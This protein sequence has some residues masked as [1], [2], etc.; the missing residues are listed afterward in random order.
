MFKLRPYQQQAVEAVYGHLR[1]RDDNPCVVLPTGTG[2]SVVLAQIAADS[3]QRWSGRVLILAHVKEL[4][5]Q[6]ADKI[7]R[8]CPELDVG[9]YSAG[10]NRRDTYHSVIAAGIQSVYKRAEELGAFDIVTVDEAHLIAP[11]GEG[12][13]RSFLADA[14]IINPNLRIIGLTATPF[15]MKGGLICKP[16]N[17]LNHICYEAGLKEMIAQGY[18]SPLISKSGRAEADLDDLHIRGG[19]FI[20]SEA[21]AAMDEETLVNSACRE[22]IELTR[23]RK[24]VLI[25]TSGIEHC[26]HVAEKITAFSGH[27]CGIVTG[28]TPAWERAELIARFKGEKVQDDFFTDKPRL[29]YLANVNVLTTGFDA[30]NTDCIVLLRPT[31]SAGL[32]VQMVGR[33]TRLFPGKTNCLILD[34]GGN[35]MRHGPVDMIRVKEP[36][37]GGGEAPAKTCPE[38]RS[39]IYAGYMTC[40]DCGYVFPPPKQQKITSKAESSGILSGQ[41]SYTDHEVNGVYYAVHHKRGAPEDA[42]RTM[43]VE[44]GIGFMQSISEWVCP[45]HSGWV[46]AKFE[47]WW[48]NRSKVPPPQTADEAVKLASDGALAVPRKIIVKSVAGEKYDRVVDY[49]I[50][51][52]PDY[53]LEPGWN[54][55]DPYNDSNDFDEDDIPF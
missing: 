15:R 51:P 43:R 31:N 48:R 37:N 9:V 44:Y 23:D 16:E 25:F 27:E 8:L 54:D 11:D 24:S 47:S 53:A 26:R 13:Y 32:L 46:R 2:K 36:G 45:E 18:L 3:V 52:V 6:N 10:L 42:P 14:Q 19:E 30:E 12:M 29:K 38:C 5:E 4:L 35:I 55:S 33:G 40:P 28:E 41:T 20:A 7:R 17:M 21:E 1:T 34:Y 22:I 49:E 39:V 50:G